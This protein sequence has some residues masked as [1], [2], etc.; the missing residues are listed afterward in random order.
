MNDFGTETTTPQKFNFAYEELTAREKK[1][2]RECWNSQF[3]SPLEVC[4]IK[5]EIAKGSLY[6]ALKNV[7]IYLINE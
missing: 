1:L 7:E 5:M 3:C 6:S 4:R 2:L